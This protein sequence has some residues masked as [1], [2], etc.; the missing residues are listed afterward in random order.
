MGREALQNRIQGW[1]RSYKFFSNSAQKLS[2]NVTSRKED[3]GLVKFISWLTCTC[4]GVYRV[5]VGQPTLHSSQVIFCIRSI[6]DWYVKE[7][8]ESCIRY[9]IICRST[10]VR[11]VAHFLRH[12]TRHY[13]C[14]YL[15]HI[16]FS[17]SYAYFLM[18]FFPSTGDS[19]NYRRYFAIFIKRLCGYAWLNAYGCGAL[20]V[21]FQSQVIFSS[22]CRIY[23]STYTA[24]VLVKCTGR[25][26]HISLAHAIYLAGKKSTRTFFSAHRE[27]II[28]S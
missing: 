4:S 6:T 1:W 8:I 20:S 13:Y 23:S 21:R 28:S 9:Y 10:I 26:A 17:E 16:R 3:T 22:V 14:S 7:N 2:Q 12:D 24:E 15:P 5:K 11:I 18:N 25:H 19:K 27:T